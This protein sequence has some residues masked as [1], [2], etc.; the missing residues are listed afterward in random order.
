MSAS[1]S[2]FFGLIQQKDVAGVLAALAERPALAS[3]RDAYLG[4]TP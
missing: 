2:D 3:A 4:S 1:E